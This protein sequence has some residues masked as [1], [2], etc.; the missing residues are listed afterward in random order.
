[1]SKNKLVIVESPAKAKT[2]EKILGKSYKVLS[3]YGHIIDLPKT[4]IGVDV[5]ENFKPSYNTIKGKGPI[6]KQLRDAAK[7]A[8][9]VFLA[10]DPDREGESIAWHIANVLKLNQDENNRIEFNEITE[11]AIKEAVK[12]PRKI[13]L[14]R[15]N[16]QQARR[17]LDRLV[18]YEI[19]P[20]L[21]KMIFPNTSAG[22]VQSVA[23][24]IICELEDKIKSFTPEKYWDVKGIF[25][26]KYHTDSLAKIINS[27]ITL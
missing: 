10:S 6:V 15:V 13:N 24:K 22:R 20:F 14:N 1:M 21:W 8:D 25:E 26:N 12:N 23:L 18:G 4:K 5:N 17:I 16:S 3:S 9:K 27:S 11:K 7:K 19:S 2:I